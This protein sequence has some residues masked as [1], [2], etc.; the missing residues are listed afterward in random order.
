MDIIYHRIR[1]TMNI[2]IKYIY[3]TIEYTIYYLNININM[4]IIYH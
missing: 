3:F 2:N 4:N 1:N